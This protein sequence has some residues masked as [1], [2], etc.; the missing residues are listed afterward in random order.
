MKK[1]EEQD[2]LWQLLGKAKGHA[3]SPFF[4]RNVLREIRSARPEKMGKTGNTGIVGWL[5]SQWRLVVLSGATA[6]LLVLSGVHLL[7]P[8]RDGSA[9]QSVAANNTQNQA[10]P[11][12]PITGS[13]YEVIKNLDTELLA[14]EE[15][16]IWLDDSAQ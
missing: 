1:F 14:Y 2:E 7:G 3:V 8:G 12:K 15:H 11:A 16:S 6:A 9:S 10:E 5:R 4:A 13:D